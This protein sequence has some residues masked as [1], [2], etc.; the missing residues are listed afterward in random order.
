MAFNLFVNKTNSTLFYCELNPE[1]PDCWADYEH[2]PFKLTNG[3][4]ISAIAMSLLII[5]ALGGNILVCTAF[6]VYRRLRKTT[7][8]FIISLA[9]SDILVATVAMPM[10]LS[11]E[12]TAWQNL[13]AW[14]DF[15]TLLQFWNWFDILAGVSSI[16]NLTA[17]SIDR[18]FSIMQPLLHRTRMTSSIAIVMV[19]AAWLYSIIVAS[20]SLASLQ[21]YTAI[22]SAVGFFIPL[23][24]ILIAY[25]LIYIRV[26]T[27]GYGAHQEKDWNL[28][29]TL[30][31][32]ISFFVVCWLPFFAFSLFYHYCFSCQF[33]Q[34]TLAY[35]IS[36]TKWMHYLNSC[37][38]P[39]IY[40]LFNMNF[41]NAF[42]ALFRT[43][44][45]S[46][47][48]ES[49]YTSPATDGNETSLKRQIKNLRRKLRPKKHDK[50]SFL[51]NDPETASVCVTTVPASS[52]RNSSASQAASSDN[53]IAPYDVESLLPDGGD[54]VHSQKGHLKDSKYP[55]ASTNNNAQQK[56][57]SFAIQ[58]PRFSLAGSSASENDN[59]DIAAF[60]E[61]HS[62]TSSVADAQKMSLLDSQESCV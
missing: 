49:D 21:N 3:K 19:I 6:F 54:S 9:I 33:K 22:V 47:P 34:E 40:G 31:I 46:S 12:V 14:I 52:N 58:D 23:L 1:D 26:K 29:R 13:P 43:C 2:I 39:F 50:D 55:R 7:N 15:T 20:L 62:S 5:V 41:K 53:N 27:G 48:A 24:V 60:L 32:V 56:E 28:E 4:I 18:C 35:L 59:A 16:T 38:N 8:F 61:Q 10:W 17:I 36:F 44:F 11:Y 30:I 42:R 45:S 51:L 25:F 57:F 37:C